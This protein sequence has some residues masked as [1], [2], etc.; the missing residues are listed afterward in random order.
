MG[1]WDDWLTFHPFHFS[2]GPVLAAEA[3]MVQMGPSG[4]PSWFPL[5]WN[6]CVVP[7]TLMDVDRLL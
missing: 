5:V 3:G 1:S 2:D 4:L 6:V 7:Q